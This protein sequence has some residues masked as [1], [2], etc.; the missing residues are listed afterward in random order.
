MRQEFGKRIEIRK[1]K[2]ENSEEK[3]HTHATHEWGTGYPTQL[4]LYLIRDTL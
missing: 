2:L 4:Q 1:L 3:T